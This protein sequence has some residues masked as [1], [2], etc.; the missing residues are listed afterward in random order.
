MTPRESWLLAQANGVSDRL[1][2]GGEVVGKRPAGL[3]TPLRFMRMQFNRLPNQFH[4]FVSVVISCE[5][6]ARFREQ[7]SNVSRLGDRVEFAFKLFQSINCNLSFGIMHGGE[8]RRKSVGK[9]MKSRRG[10]QSGPEDRYRFISCG[11]LAHL[12]KNQISL[13]QDFYDI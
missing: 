12:T 13:D 2:E 9:C 7:G 10:C 6:A 8:E 11:V 3:E 4:R 5:R 1:L